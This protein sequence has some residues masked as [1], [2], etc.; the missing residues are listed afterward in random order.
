[1]SLR[2]I[3]LTS[4]TLFCAV[5]LPSD[6]PIEGRWEANSPDPIG[7]T[8]Q[9]ELRF[10][11]ANSELT[12]VLHTPGRDIPLTKVRLQGRALTFDAMRDLRGHS[13]LY[14]YDGTLSGNTLDFTVQNEDG[15][16]FFR[17]TAHRE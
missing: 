5:A 8:E 2:A 17:F 7:K 14:H 1:M 15:S 12:G 11:A 10:T 16:S 6:N 4:V 9:I 13:V 3:F